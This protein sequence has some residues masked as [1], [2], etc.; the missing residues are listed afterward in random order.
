[1]LLELLRRRPETIFVTIIRQHNQLIVRTGD[2]KTMDQIRDLVCRLDVPTPVVLLEVKVLSIDLTDTFTSVFD[3]QFTDGKLTAGG[4]TTGNILPLA[5]D[6][7]ST[8]ARRF[9]SI[10]P[11]ATAGS[12][13]SDRDLLFQVVSANFRARLQL[14]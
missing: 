2:P 10:T 11:A 4:F 7:L 14:L 9:A 6:A 8:A 5:S 1:V 3:Y 12:P 13:G